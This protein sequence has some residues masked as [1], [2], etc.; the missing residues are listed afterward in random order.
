MHHKCLALAALLLAIGAEAAAA[1]NAGGLLGLFGGSA[2]SE[3][4]KVPRNEI[5]CIDRGLAPQN[6]NAQTLAKQGIS[7]NDPRLAQLRASCHKETAKPPG[8]PVAA[9]APVYVV[10]GLAL[11]SRVKPDGA[12]YREYQCMPSEQFAG[13]TW[14]QKQRQEKG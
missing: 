7:P 1:Q 13:F 12:A 8:Q 9:Q 6:T 5:G 14:C 11:G 10:D 3:W 4:P 2:Q